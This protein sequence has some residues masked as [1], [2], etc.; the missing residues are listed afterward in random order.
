MLQRN[1]GGF[2]YLLLHLL[3]LAMRRKQLNSLRFPYS[4]SPFISFQ[5]AS[6][7]LQY[8]C[9]VFLYDSET[10]P[11]SFFILC[12]ATNF[13]STIYKRRTYSI[14]YPSPIY[15]TLAHNPLQ[16]HFFIP[17]IKHCSPSSDRSA[18]RRV[19]LKYSGDVEKIAGVRLN[20]AQYDEVGNTSE[21]L[22]EGDS[23]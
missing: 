12:P 17:A 11:S 7:D 21:G 8:I 14:K 22:E 4:S 1:F 2:F 10:K 13:S 3:S 5:A 20:S 9:R 16:L 15:N 19:Y 23:A 6:I 18:S